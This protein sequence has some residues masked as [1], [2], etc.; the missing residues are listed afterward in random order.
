MFK[1]GDVVTPLVLIGF[2]WTNS[3]N[4]LLHFGGVVVFP[5]QFA[6]P[7]EWS[8]EFWRGVS[9]FGSTAGSSTTISSP[10]DQPVKKVS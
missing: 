2:S 4:L 10:A 9:E 8:T 3:H 1:T 7:F 5:T 6:T